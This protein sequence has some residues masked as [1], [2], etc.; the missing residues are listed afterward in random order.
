MN[1]KKSHF[2]H[3][4]A[5]SKLVYRETPS[6]GDQEQS[7]GEKPDSDFL[8]QAKESTGELLSR[9]SGVEEMEKALDQLKD[10]STEARESELNNVVKPLE[11]AEKAQEEIP[12]IEREIKEAMNAHGDLAKLR[13]VLIDD[14]SESPTQAA[15]KAIEEIFNLEGRQNFNKRREIWA[16]AAKAHGEE[17]VRFTG[18]PLQNQTILGYLTRNLQDVE[19]TTDSVPRR[20]RTR[21]TTQRTLSATE[22]AIENH[23]DK[24]ALRELFQN[25]NVEPWRVIQAVFNTRTPEANQAKRAELWQEMDRGE[26]YR[27]SGDQNRAIVRFLREKFEDYELAKDL[28]LAPIVPERATRA[29]EQQESLRGIIRI[30][31]EWNQANPV[32]EVNIVAEEAKEELTEEQIRN[33]REVLESI[34]QAFIDGNSVSE[35]RLNLDNI[36]EE[37]RNKLGDSTIKMLEFPKSG[38]TPT[39]TVNKF[40]IYDQGGILSRASLGITE[41]KRQQLGENTPEFRTFEARSRT[42]V[43]ENFRGSELLT[44]QGQYLLN[45]RHLTRQNYRLEGLA[46]LSESDIDRNWGSLSGVHRVNTSLT[47]PPFNL[48]NPKLTALEMMRTRRRARERFSRRSTINFSD[49]FNNSQIQESIAQVL[50]GLD[51]EEHLKNANTFLNYFQS[52]DEKGEQRTEDEERIF[53]SLAEDVLVPILNLL[54]A[55]QDLKMPES[56]PVRDEREMVQIMEESLAQDEE[57]L[58]TFESLRELCFFTENPASAWRRIMGRMAGATNEITMA[59]IDGKTFQIDEGSWRRHTSP[60]AALNTIINQGSL[61]TLEDGKK[62]FNTEHLTSYINERIENGVRQMVS[63]EVRGQISEDTPQNEVDE[64]FNRLMAEKYPLDEYRISDI[65]NPGGITEKQQIAFQLGFLF[66][67]EVESQR[68]VEVLRDKTARDILLS[69]D[70]SPLERELFENLLQEAEEND[71]EIPPEAA[72]RIRSRLRAF[73]GFHIHNGELVGVGLGV[74]M[75]FNVGDRKFNFALSGVVNLSGDGPRAIPSLTFHTTLAEVG[76]VRFG[77]AA[78]IS[79]LGAGVGASLR[80]EGERATLSMGIGANWTLQSIVPAVG[81]GLAI[82]WDEQSMRRQHER[83]SEERREEMG[84]ARENWENWKSLSRADKLET[85]KSTPILWNSLVSQLDI[86]DP[87]NLTEDQELIV[88]AAAEAAYEQ[89]TGDIFKDVNAPLIGGVNLGAMVVASTLMGPGVGTA[90]G[91]I[92]GTKIRIG[93]VEIF[94]PKRTERARILNEASRLRVETEVQ[95]Q[96]ERLESGEA[97]GEITELTPDLYYRPESELGMGIRTENKEVCLQNIEPGIENYNETFRNN[98]LSVELIRH[99]GNKIELKIHDTSTIDLEVHIDPALNLSK[100]LGLDEGTDSLFLLGDIRDLIIEEEIFEFPH[101][102]DKSLSNIRKVITIRNRDSVSGE[103][104]RQWITMNEMDFVQRLHRE[105]RYRIESGAGGYEWGQSSIQRLSDNYLEQSEENLSDD[106]RFLTEQT[107]DFERERQMLEGDIRDMREALGALT[108]Q[109][110]NRQGPRENFEASLRELFRNPDFEKEF[111]QVVDKPEEIITLI[112]QFSQETGHETLANLTN[113]EINIALSFMLNEWFVIKRLEGTRE[114]L[115]RLG[116]DQG[117]RQ[118]LQR[119]GIRRIDQLHRMS[120]QEIENLSDNISEREAEEVFN[121][122]RE[123]QEREL[124]DEEKITINGELATYLEGIRTWMTPRFTEEFRKAKDAQGTLIQST[125][126]QMAARFLSDMYDP[127]IEQLRRTENPVDFRNLSLERMGA[128]RF[129]SGT[130]IHD[131]Q[132]RQALAETMNYEYMGTEEANREINRFGYGLLTDSKTEYGLNSSNQVERDIA[133]SLL[134]RSTPP[135]RENENILRTPL[136]VQILS[137]KAF[138]YLAGPNEGQAEENHRAMREIARGASPGDVANG[139]RAMNHFSELMQKIQDAQINGEILNLN[140]IRG[141]RIE[142]DMTQTK[143]TG[144]LYG[145]CFNP[146]FNIV[147]GGKLSMESTSGAAGTVIRSVETTG[148]EQGKEATYIAII[149][150][151]SRSRREPEIPPEIPEAPE[152]EV[153]PARGTGGGTGGDTRGGA[154]QEIETPQTGPEVRREDEI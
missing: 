46:G 80:R 12:P 31:E 124:S 122:V 62:K 1:N 69:G 113:K 143:V 48:E 47:S 102:T 142:I 134:L 3:S 105:G 85:V 149:G 63:A 70:A 29:P 98:G 138:R 66:E 76:K 51:Q 74:P 60:E 82:E 116:L 52:L 41:I 127:I 121:A 57:N 93:Q 100:S 125:P 10:D 50:A 2:I 117:T 16:E 18:Q 145:Q 135:A 99:E 87:A 78:N 58:K 71:F 45:Y 109:E 144:G 146:S 40:G 132:W 27:G 44:R 95:G 25:E 42:S 36:G 24:D 53:R 8:R 43:T 151:I 91:A 61:Y 59:D 73:G 140:G 75:E 23:P 83:L 114:G 97:S 11:E 131:P 86:E 49:V 139:E 123:F 130:R 21:E 15:I 88:L 136:A 128:G 65:T 17:N 133:R 32:F 39:F 19:R 129:V 106:L 68:S 115:G 20:E 79:L 104:D 54:D 81:G 72:L 26:R 103:R 38:T 77:G 64:L 33:T 9:S 67:R 107:P 154:G 150:G 7:S 92:A 126:E 101:R 4:F 89:A 118:E 147:E 153:R 55:M 90:I 94:V 112:Q 111:R 14:A 6:R 5:E 37:I 141:S 35:V 30:Q 120:Q 28:P 84:M 119:S 108:R 34:K 110:Y 96:L 152:P 148:F 137:T 56:I 22:K 13:E